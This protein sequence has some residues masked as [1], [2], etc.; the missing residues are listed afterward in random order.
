MRRRNLLLAGCLALTL[1]S[2]TTAQ[3][4]PQWSAR[5]GYYA[6]QRSPAPYYYIEPERTAPSYY[7]EPAPL[8]RYVAPPAPAPSPAPPPVASRSLPARVDP[9]AMEPAD[10]DC[11]W[12]RLCNLWVGT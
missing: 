10:P 8:P 4:V 7:A 2:C 12:W 5:P 1:A 9:P 11:G 6:P 3:Q